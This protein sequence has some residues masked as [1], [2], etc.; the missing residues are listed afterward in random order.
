MSGKQSDAV[1]RSIYDR[2]WRAYGPQHWWPVSSNNASPQ[3][4]ATEMVLGAILTQNTSWTNVERA[5][6]RLHKAGR[7]NWAALRDTSVKRLAQ[8]I[9]PAGTY[10]VKAKRIQAFV[11]YL[12]RRHDGRLDDLLGGDLDGCR[13]TLL[14]IYGIGH[15]TADA[16]LLYAGGRPI[17]VVDAYTTRILR[18]HKVIEARESYDRVQARFHRSA[19]ADA[20]VYNEYHALL[21]ELGKRHCKSKALCDGCPLADMPHDESL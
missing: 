8:L 10:R 15:E 5:I 20:R 21:V 11:D 12:W 18:R 7:M 13:R 14:S 19:P 16:I 17:F 9:R 3:A 6:A 2:L 4:A 1:I